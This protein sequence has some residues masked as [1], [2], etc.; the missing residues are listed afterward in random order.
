L[1]LYLAVPSDQPVIGARC[2]IDHRKTKLHI[3]YT[4][5]N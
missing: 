3:T 2:V 5:L 4:K 1:G